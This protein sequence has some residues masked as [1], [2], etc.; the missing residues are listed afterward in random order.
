MCITGLLPSTHYEEA[1][2]LIRAPFCTSQGEDVVAGIRTP[3]VIDRLAET[4]PEAY[5]ELV[6]DFA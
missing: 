6:R 4:L 3:D 2:W 1:P 5:K